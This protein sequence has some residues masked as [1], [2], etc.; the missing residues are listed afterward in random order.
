MTFLKEWAL[1]LTAMAIA[2]VVLFFVLDLVGRKTPAPVSTLAETVGAA[3]SGQR[4]RF[5]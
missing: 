2:L 5:G 3:A 4:Y 1:S